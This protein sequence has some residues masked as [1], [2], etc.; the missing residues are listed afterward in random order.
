[1]KV[2]R[3][4]LLL[5]AGGITAVG[6]VATLVLGSTLGLFSATTTQGPNTFVAG[7]VSLTQSA[8]TTCST[9]NI[10]PGDASTGWTPA[11]TLQ[12]CKFTVTYNNGSSS[13][14]PAWLGLDVSVAST[15][16]GVTQT[17]NG[18]GTPPTAAGGLYDGTSS[19]LQFLV[20][21][22][23]TSYLSGTTWHDTTA[24]SG[25]APSE[26]NLLVSSTA[27]P[28]GTAVTFTVD[29]ALPSTASNAYQQAGSSMTLT[30]HAVQSQHNGSTGAC[31]VGNPCAL[32]TGSWNS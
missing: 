10:V 13:T 7:T 4:R 31:T 19:G 17:P 11:G 2:S 23:T 9:S 18:G 27:V 32:G 6:A 26:T 20:S 28:Q 14:T 15:H 1:M 5:T 30:V 24:A 25:T 12:Q 29:Y 16:V 3:K 8:T 21:D 22:G